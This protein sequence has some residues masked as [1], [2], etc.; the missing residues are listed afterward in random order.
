ML[1]MSHPGLQEYDS[2]QSNREHSMPSPNAGLLVAATSQRV[3]K[4]MNARLAQLLHIATTKQFYIS[5]VE[6]RF[7]RCKHRVQP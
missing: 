7:R 6:L 5:A 3:S 4:H 2:T 1:Q